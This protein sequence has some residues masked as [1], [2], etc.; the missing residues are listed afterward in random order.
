[1]TPQLVQIMEKIME[2][3]DCIKGTVDIVTNGTI[4]FPDELLA[5]FQRNSDKMRVIMSNYG[6]DLSGKIR[7]IEKALIE[8]KIPYRIQNYA[9]DSTEWTNDG[10]VDFSDHSLK[11]DTVEKL[12]IQGKKCFVRQGRYYVINAGELHPCFR[13]YWR[14]HTGIMELEDSEYIDLNQVNMDVNKE[15][16]KLKKINEY[17]YYK[18]CAYCNGLYNGIERYKPA[19]QLEGR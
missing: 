13:Q 16:D 15:L 10:W 2:Y 1:M 12:E 17:P 4:M 19:E 14:M 6:K 3:R 11:H 7:D 8:R 9:S 18:S 5:L